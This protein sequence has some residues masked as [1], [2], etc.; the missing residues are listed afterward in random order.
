M[1]RKYL[2][3]SV[4]VAAI[5]I[6]ASVSALVSVVPNTSTKS[7]QKSGIAGYTVHAPIYI[8]GNSGFQGANGSTGISSGSGTQSDPYIIQG[9]E[10]DASGYNYAI[11]VSSSSVFFKIVDCYLHHASQ[12]GVYFYGVSNGLVFNS[13][14]SNNTLSGIRIHD[15]G[16]NTISN[17][18]CSDNSQGMTFVTSSGMKLRNNT[19]VNNGL[20]TYG[21]SLGAWT[22]DIDTSNTVNG[23]PLYYYKST[24]GGTVPAGAGQ[25]ILA[26]CSDMIVEN[27]SIS[28]ASYAIN[29]GYCSNISIANNSCVN[30]SDLG[31]Y[32]WYSNGN[33]LRNNSLNSSGKGAG[34]QVYTSSSNTLYDNVC[35]GHGSNGIELYYSSNSNTLARNTLFN[36]TLNGIM[37]YQSSSNTVFNNTCISNGYYGITV[38]ASS[39]NALS[40]NNCSSN[41]YEGIYLKSSSGSTLTNNTCNLNNQ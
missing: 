40:N 3:V 31:I 22:H 29:I 33:S 23:K 34:I 24:V 20:V 1:R 36:N 2:L 7:P 41:D 6:I 28:G 26:G 19:L 10:I 35:T 21:Y 17:N 8:I 25:V 4:V 38:Q 37:I 15:S 30:N 32:V 16:S 9:W 39:G 11:Y 27:Q 18:T 13:T 12:T 14:C 5:M